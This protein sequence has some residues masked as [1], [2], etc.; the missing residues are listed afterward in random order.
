MCTGCAQTSGPGRLLPKG[1]LG[2]VVSSW[3]PGAGGQKGRDL[4]SHLLKERTTFAR[5]ARTLFT[6]QP[7][8]K[9]LLQV[10]TI[11]VSTGCHPWEL[12]SPNL[13]FEATGNSPARF[14][15]EALCASS[16][17]QPAPQLLV[18]P[19]PSGSASPSLTAGVSSARR[20]SPLPSAWLTCLHPRDLGHV[21]LSHVSQMRRNPE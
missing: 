17:P 16:S 6:H 8:W 10:N 3:T 19:R 1:G 11:C 18:R 12:K 21:A 13:P 2:E 15:H 4:C 9:A 5:K 7:R 20:L 14:L